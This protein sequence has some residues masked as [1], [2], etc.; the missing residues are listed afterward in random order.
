MENQELF[1]CECKSLEHQV[2]FWYNEDVNELHLYV[3]LT[4]EVNKWNR[5]WNAVKYVFGYRSK[6]GDFDNF[7][8]AL[9]DVEKLKVVLE[10][11]K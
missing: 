10:K 3:H 4:P 5:V 9:S 8:L 6:Y 1:V 11:M 2:A 7:Q